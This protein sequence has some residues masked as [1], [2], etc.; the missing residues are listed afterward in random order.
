MMP[1]RRRLARHGVGRPE[2]G[3]HL[4]AGHGKS[5]HADIQPMS[6]SLS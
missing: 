6:G 2:V 5:C 1:M 4:I 3:E